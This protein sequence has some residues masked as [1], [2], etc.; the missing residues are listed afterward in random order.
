MCRFLL[1]LLARYGKYA[2][3]QPNQ[4][5]TSEIPSPATLFGGQVGMEPNQFLPR[6][7]LA[8]GFVSYCRCKQGG[9]ADVV[10]GTKPSK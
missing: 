9:S 5:Y 10:D 1:D 2:T 8:I 7:A 3:A 6:S 4:E